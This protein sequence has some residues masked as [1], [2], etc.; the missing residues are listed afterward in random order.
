MKNKNISKKN[1]LLTISLFLLVSLCNTLL[2]R[3]E[4]N[5]IVFRD[6]SSFFVKTDITGEVVFSSGDASTSI[7]WA[8]DN[9]PAMGIN[10]GEVLIEEGSYPLTNCVMVKDNVWLHG[11]GPSTK[12][13]I[14]GQVSEAIIIQDASMAVVSNLFLY[15]GGNEIRLNKGIS[16]ER[17]IN[18]QVLNTEVSGFNRGIS[19]YGESSLTLINN[20]KV[21]DNQTNIDISNGGGVIGRWLPLLVTENTVEGGNT[22]IFCGAM[23]THIMDNI[24]TGVTGYGIHASKNSIVISG[25]KL[26][27]IGGDYA[28]YGSGAELNCTHNIISNVKGG[29]IRT[30]DRWGNFTQNKIK[31]CGTEEKPAVGILIESDNLPEGPG[32]SKV[33]YKN[34]IHNDEDHL[35]LEYGIK[36]SG[37]NNIISGNEI[38]NFLKKA[39]LSQ[40]ERPILEDNNEIKE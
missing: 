38:K 20:N 29:G 26:T 28:I 31:N 33:V 30:R 13:F 25:N 39:V 36:E 19:N 11:K 3:P 2:A 15:Q 10:G 1:L 22:G 12:L 34:E 27:N 32:E 23:V 6:G 18:C 35:G 17:S 8:I 16:L 9:L 4:Q 7:Q 21:V 24:I 14:Q 5:F 40:G 37:I